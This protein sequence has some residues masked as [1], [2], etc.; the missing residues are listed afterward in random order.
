MKRENEEMKLDLSVQDAELFEDTFA[1]FEENAE[2]T[3]AEKK[4]VLSSVMRKAGFE[5]NEIINEKRKNITASKTDDTEVRRGRIQVKRGGIIAACIAVLTVGAVTVGMLHMNNINAD[6]PEPAGQPTV[7]GQSTDAEDTDTSDDEYTDTM[8]DNAENIMPDL[9]GR[10]LTDV[11]AEYDGKLSFDVGYDYNT[12]YEEGIIF[13]QYTPAGTPFKEGDSLELKVSKGKMKEIIPDV[14]GSEREVAES[15]LYAARFNPVV[16]EIY[17]EEVPE[18]IAIKT[19]PPAGTEAAVESKITLF[20]SSGKT[21]EPETVT[22]P[23]VVGMKKDEA[24]LLLKE[25]GLC[26]RSKWVLGSEE[27]GTVVKQ[28]AEPDTTLNKYDDITICVSEG[29]TEPVKLTISTPLPADLHGTYRIDLCDGDG[30]V[31]YTKSINA[32]TLGEVKTFDFDLEGIGTEKFTIIITSDET[33]K[34]VIYGDFAVDFTNKT[35]D[36]D[37]NLNTAD[38]LALNPA[39]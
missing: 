12:E 22:V 10:K 29:V 34:S 25:S 6:I 18:G 11:L 26:V 16:K 3:D 21:G 33:D 30:T 20:I 13:G 32:D 17:D 1:G 31:K 39:E 8:D 23:D 38:L 28:S 4:R 36:M 5:M 24:M 9:V 37:K 35:A 14:S 27:K 2:V 7:E 15:L 19:D